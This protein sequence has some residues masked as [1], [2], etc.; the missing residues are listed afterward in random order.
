MGIYEIILLAIAMLFM[1]TLYSMVGHGGGSG[2]L[3]VLAIAAI[4]PEQMRPT[5]LL[6]NVLV[7]LVA[8]WKFSRT[9][10]F[11]KDLF[12]PLVI[13]SIPAAFVGGSIE[14]SNAVYKP[15]VGLVLIYAAI[16]LFTPIKGVEKTNKP[17]IPLVLFAGVAIG[18]LSGI[19]GIG[20]GIFLSPL[21]L[22]LGW[23]TAKQTAAIS[24]P[25]I[26]VNSI[27][28]LGGIVARQS[29]IPVDIEFVMPLIIA[30]GI[31]GF[32]GASIGSKKLGHQGLRTVLGVV[33]LLASLKM[34]FTMNPTTNQPQSDTV[35]STS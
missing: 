23:T 1:A 26:L 13:A 31:G 10:M 16:K 3:A 24:A 17:F 27:A 25:F 8:T 9:G 6:L 19:I 5:A 32:V 2:Y 15:M 21:I 30:V 20:G 34:F 12:F 29:E 22:L 28:G 4:A 14:L 7:S 11:R 33:L 18:M 35:K